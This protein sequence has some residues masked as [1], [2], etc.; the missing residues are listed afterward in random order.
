MIKDVKIK[1][2]FNKYD[3]H[4]Q[5]NNDGL[6]I[7]S[8]R[9]GKGK[10][11]I[12]N[13][14][15]YILS[16]NISDLYRYDFDF[17]E[18]FFEN[19][20]SIKIDR[21]SLIPKINNIKTTISRSSLF[22]ILKN[23]VNVKHNEL[24][25]VLYHKAIGY[26]TIKQNK[27]LDDLLENNYIPK[28][29]LDEF[30]NFS[31]SYKL[32]VDSFIYHSSLT[33]KIKSYLN[34]YDADVIY[35]PTFRRI[36][37]SFKVFKFSTELSLN[38]K[39]TDLIGTS[40]SLIHFG[41][42]DIYEGLKKY[43]DEMKHHLLESFIAKEEDEKNAHAISF[44]NLESKMEGFISVCNKYLINK[45]VRSFDYQTIIIDEKNNELD[46]EMLSSGEKQ[47]VSIFYNTHLRNKKFILLMDEPEISL[48]MEWQETLVEDIQSSNNCLYALIMTHSPFIFSNE[49]LRSKTVDLSYFLHENN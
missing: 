21:D 32:D 41:M 26:D 12:L 28:F 20:L 37:N 13:I 1:G 22:N 46:W 18:V 23:S 15:Y 4:I 5:F 6:L 24:L 2:L 14:I 36:E 31:N 10:T 8:S 17:I 48:S 34:N 30:K 42:S 44:R 47:I 35:L 9:N 19:N 49:K 29:I 38:L 40:E 45:K 25:D 27:Y 11:T 3:V 7:V 33:K 39:K 16:Y 43:N